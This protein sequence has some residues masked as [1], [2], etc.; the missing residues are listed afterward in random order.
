[1]H[2]RKRNLQLITAR[3]RILRS[4]QTDVERMLWQTLRQKQVN[5][6]RFRRQHPVGQYIVDFA[7]IERKLVI[8][9]DG[10]QHQERREYDE[11][12][13]GFLNERG[14][15]VLRFWNNDVIE[16]LDGVLTEI[17]NALKSAPPSQPSP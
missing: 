2:H 8:E 11:Q 16:N 17:A 4:N 6:H 3:S 15:R 13:T 1:M 12:R 9:L 14:W 7:C 5:G 10:G